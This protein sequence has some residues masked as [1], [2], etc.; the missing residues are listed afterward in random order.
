MF[1]FN[2]MSCHAHFGIA[3]IAT[4]TVAKPVVVIMTVMMNYR[5]CFPMYV[6][7]YSIKHGR[8]PVLPIV[9]VKDLLWH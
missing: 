4:D 3:C 1:F 5:I 6:C 7:M 9:S 2:K 8:S